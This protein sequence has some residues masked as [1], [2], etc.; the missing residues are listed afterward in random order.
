LAGHSSTHGQMSP[1]AGETYERLIVDCCEQRQL[2]NSFN[3]VPTPPIQRVTRAHVISRDA[4]DSR[5]AMWG[6]CL[7]LLHVMHMTCV[8]WRPWLTV[9]H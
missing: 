8:M 5:H 1:F 3:D 7:V 4:F 6:V 2:C 9:T